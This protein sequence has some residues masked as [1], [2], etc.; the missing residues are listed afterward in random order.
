MPSHCDFRGFQ[1]PRG[2]ENSRFFNLTHPFR[3]S[4]NIIWTRLFKPQIQLKRFQHYLRN[5]SSIFLIAH[6]RCLLVY[7]CSFHTIRQQT[8][9]RFELL[10]MKITWHKIIVMAWSVFV[11]HAT[12]L[13]TLTL[14]TNSPTTSKH[15]ST[16][17][18]LHKS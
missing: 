1:K 7:F 8:S 18:I 15:K 4:T 11:F 16:R 5:K 17:S 12:P 14:S 10:S 3:C 6:S 2:I 9:G 13:I